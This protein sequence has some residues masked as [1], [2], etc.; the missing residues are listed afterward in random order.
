MFCTKPFTL[1]SEGAKHFPW[2]ICCEKYI[3]DCTKADASTDFV[4]NKSFSQHIYIF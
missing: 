4:N 1:N 3:T 2:L